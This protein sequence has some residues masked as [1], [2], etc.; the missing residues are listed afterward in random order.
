ML[1]S[2][3]R[4]AL[5]WLV[6]WFLVAVWRWSGWCIFFFLKN[7]KIFAYVENSPY[8]CSQKSEDSPLD[9]AKKRNGNE[10]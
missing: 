3:G 6:C 9:M 8:L 5:V 1:V 2:G 10:I 7:L 4:L